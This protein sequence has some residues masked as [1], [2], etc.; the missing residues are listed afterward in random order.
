MNSW[1]LLDIEG[2]PSVQINRSEGRVG[3][4]RVNPMGMRSADLK[5]IGDGCYA[6]TNENGATTKLET[7]QPQ[8]MP[9]DERI[10]VLASNV[11]D[12]F[13]KNLASL[14]AVGPQVIA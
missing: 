13:N 10:A 5:K 11:F 12:E 3:F 7:G 14:I 8:L 9:R 1:I 6:C 2:R 4:P